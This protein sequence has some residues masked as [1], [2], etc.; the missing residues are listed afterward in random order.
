MWVGGREDCTARALSEPAPTILGGAP[1]R[2]GREKCAS[3]TAVPF[4]GSPGLCMLG[5][6]VVPVPGP[7]VAA[8]DQQRHHPSRAGR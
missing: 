6:T 8:D 3:R 4:T 2:L 5:C 7:R 1:P